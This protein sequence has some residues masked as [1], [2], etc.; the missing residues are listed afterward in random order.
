MTLRWRMPSTD[1]H[2]SDLCGGGG[3]DIDA[4]YTQVNDVMN[5]DMNDMNTDEIGGTTAIRAAA[6]DVEVMAKAACSTQHQM[7]QFGQ[8]TCEMRA[9]VVS[10]AD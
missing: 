4:D 1:D 5:D 8:R 3:E 2:S 10:I 6:T 7:C 9:S